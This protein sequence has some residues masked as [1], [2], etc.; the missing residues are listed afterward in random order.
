MPVY[1]VEKY[2]RSA[3]DSILHQTFTDY[4]LILVDDCSPDNSPAICDKYVALD[5][6]ISV[7]HNKKNMGLSGARNTGFA[8]A[9]GQY[10]MYIDSDDTVTPDML[11]KLFNNSLNT[12]ITVFGINVI[13]ENSNGDVT[14]RTTLRC[15]EFFA[16]SRETIGNAFLHL[17]RAKIFPYACNKVYR[18]E[19]LKSTALEFETTKLI[20]DFLFNIQIFQKAKTVK[21]ISDAFYN[22]RKL[23]TQTLSNTYSPLFFELAKRK[24]GL[25]K[26]FLTNMN[27]INGESLDLIYLN[28]MKHVVSAFIRNQSPSAN[29]ST[30]EKNDF[31]LETLSDET[32]L[33]V[34]NN[35]NPH[36]LQNRVVFYILKT[37]SPV[38]CRML[39]KIISLFEKNVR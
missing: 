32:V 9:V 6:R 10:I 38:L 30:K 1:N 36:G 28:H 11:E 16:D 5:K 8:A 4:E 26:E 39:A 3:I 34:L 25:E 31:I 21:C 7:I 14:S 13:H 17:S 33:Q 27:I 29:L 35:Y 23:S 37:K 2:L 19:F 18:R 12:D 22:Y 20:E 24:Y 15:E